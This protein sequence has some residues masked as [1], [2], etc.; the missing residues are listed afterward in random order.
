MGIQQQKLQMLREIVAEPD[1]DGPRLAFAD[2]LE[3]SGNQN[4][5]ELIRLQC[6][7]AKTSER[8]APH[9]DPIQR[10][11]SLKSRCDKKWRRSL[12]ELGVKKFEIRR[13]MIEMVTLNAS[14]ALENGHQLLQE[15]PTIRHLKVTELAPHIDTFIDSP[16]LSKI[17][18]LDLSWNRLDSLAALSNGAYFD[19]VETLKLG[20]NLFLAGGLREF[21]HGSGFQNLLYLDVSNAHLGARANVKT[22]FAGPMFKQIV[23]LR[24]TEMF[25]SEEALLDM[26][27]NV[28]MPNL[29]HLEIAGLGSLQSEPPAVLSQLDSLAL[30]GKCTDEFIERFCNHPFFNQFE[31]I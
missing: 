30:L 1:C 4:W 19:N 25:W 31:A 5:A 7:V 27:L 6:E 2:L 11:E 21:F 13:G 24:A 9:E 26:L 29:R 3:E 8:L 16:W 12:N 18:K 28:E 17:T 23:A 10:I 14:R 20:N 15:F 22:V